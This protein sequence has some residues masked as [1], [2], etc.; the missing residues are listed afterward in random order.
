M[1]LGPITVVDKQQVNGVLNSDEITFLGDATYPTG[2]TPGFQALVRK[3]LN[4][5]NVT[6]QYVVA[7][8]SA[9]NTPVYDVA[10]DKLKVYSGT[11][12][13]AAG[14]I[15]ATTFRLVVVSK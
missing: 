5:G 15:S 3:A 2:G 4:K 12:E 9:G 7:Q 13:H 1:A 10:N 11:S 14:D 8:D 6:I